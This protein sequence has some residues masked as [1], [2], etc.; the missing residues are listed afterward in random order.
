MLVIWWYLTMGQFTPFSMVKYSIPQASISKYPNGS[1]MKLAMMRFGIWLNLVFQTQLWLNNSGSTWVAT[2]DL[3]QTRFSWLVHHVITGVWLKRHFSWLRLKL[4]QI[5]EWFWGLG[6]MSFHNQHLSC[7]LA[8]WLR[9]DCAMH[10]ASWHSAYRW[11]FLYGLQPKWLL[12]STSQY[13]HH[14]GQLGGDFFFMT[15]V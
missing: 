7:E 15:R 12:T 13:W 5:A 9:I 4:G 8:G 3:N 1:V 14:I 11:R 10:A 6:T 2:D